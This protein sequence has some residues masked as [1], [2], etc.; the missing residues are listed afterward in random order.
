MQGKSHLKTSSVYSSVTMRLDTVLNDMFNFYVI[1]DLCCVITERLAGK[2]T[3]SAL[4]VINC[5]YPIYSLFCV[6]RFRCFIGQSI[7][8]LNFT[9]KGWLFVHNFRTTVKHNRSLVKKH[10]FLLVVF[11]IYSIEYFVTPIVVEEDVISSSMRI[12]H[13]YIP[14]SFIF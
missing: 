13:A 1:F 6:T 14:E 3:A 4:S 12:G 7:A 8:A 9:G 10:V 5:I 11:Y 2:V